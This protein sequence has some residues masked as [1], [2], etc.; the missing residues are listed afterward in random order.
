MGEKMNRI[1]TLTLGTIFT[2]CALGV[3]CSSGGDEDDGDGKAGSTSTSGTGNNTSGA[4]TGGTT[5]MTAGTTGTT[6]GTTGTTAGTT[7]NGGS[8]TGGTTGGKSVCDTGSRALPLAE[9]YIDNV[10]SMVRWDS[11]YAFSDTTPPHTPAKDRLAMGALETSTSAHVAATGIKSPTM[12]G[13]GA[14]IGFNLVNAASGETCLDVTAFDGISF[15]A[16]GTSG[17]ANI[18]KFQAIVPATQPTSEMPPG[19]CKPMTACAYIH[20]AKSITLT[21]DWAHVD[22]KFSELTSAAGKFAGNILGFNIITP[23]AAWDI[24]IDEV[25]F[26]KG[27]APT[28]PVEPPVEGG[29]G[30]GGTGAGGTGGTGGTQ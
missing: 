3:A 19:D 22:I 26:Y 30:T 15:W 28:T 24:A 17:T 4:S 10:E 29:G 25:T 7:G 23:D 1:S 5:G 27:T 6:A 16:K 11:W 8:G 2:V 21:E 14:G 20:P 9:A 13:F 12:M 18:V